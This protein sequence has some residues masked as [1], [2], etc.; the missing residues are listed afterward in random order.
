[1]QLE[2]L[3]AMAALISSGCAIIAA[4]ISVLVWRKARAGDLSKQITKGDSDAKRHIDRSIAGVNQRLS[5][6]DTRMGEVE[7]GVAR[8][9]QQQLHNLTARDLGPMHEK[10]NRL[11]ENLAA[12]TSTT[13]AMREQL[14]VVHEHLMR[15]ER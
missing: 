6:M 13:N 4:T 8:I 2:D 3:Q 5:T 10:I 14:R 15:G 11:A 1:M 9:E 7:D 12:N